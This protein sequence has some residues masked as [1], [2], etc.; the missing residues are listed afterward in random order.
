MATK[1]TE[2]GVEFTYKGQMYRITEPNW[3]KTITNA[4]LPNKVVINVNHFYK[5]GGKYRPLMCTEKEHD[6]GALSLE[7]IARH[8]YPCSVAVAI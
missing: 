8:F 5:D 7:E 6:Y 2:E 3:G 4:V 1:D